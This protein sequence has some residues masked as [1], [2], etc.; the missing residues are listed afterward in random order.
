M[1]S[2]N[3]VLMV[4]M[5]IASLRNDARQSDAAGQKCHTQVYGE[6]PVRSWADVNHTEV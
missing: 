6:R 4:S 1:Y 2:D 3:K 5:P